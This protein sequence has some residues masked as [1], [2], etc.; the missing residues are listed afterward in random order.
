MDK[1]ISFSVLIPIYYKEDPLF[2]QQ[3][4]DS[5]LNQTLLTDEIV[6]VKDGPL[7][8]E[9]NTVI[10]EYTA[11]YPKLFNIVAIEKNVG[12]GKARN[13][14]LQACKYNYVAL[15]DSD[16]IADLTRFEKQIGYLEKHP[17]IDC[18]GSNITEF[19]GEQE[20]IIS[21]KVVPLTHEEIFKFGKWRSPMN[22]MTII[23]KKDK[24]L[25]VGGY[26]S[27][28]FGED[29]LLFA[30][31]LNVGMLFHNLEDCLVNARSGQRML[32]KRVVWDKIKQEFLLFYEFKKMGYINSYQ[33]VRNVSLKFLLRIIPNW[34]RSYIYKKFLRKKYKETI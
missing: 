18:I 7:T 6:I 17:E 28:N 12:Q 31:M 16:D 23:Y 13:E 9:L 22:N 5:I 30:K 3:A 29:Y 11:K 10:E 15:M 26:N 4:L 33:F 2:F 25:E 34:L 14:G 19:E 24:V 32:A 21:K 27:F 1:K 20:N 8:E